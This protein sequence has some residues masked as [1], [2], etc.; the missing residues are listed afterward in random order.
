M[1]PGFWKLTEHN[2]LHSEAAAWSS[3]ARLD[4]GALA[5]VDQKLHHEQIEQRRGG[6]MVQGGEVPT[7]GGDKHFLSRRVFL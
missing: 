1:E 6:H 4:Q 2:T 7:Y 3:T 5:L